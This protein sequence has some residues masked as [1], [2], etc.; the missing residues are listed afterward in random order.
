MHSVKCRSNEDGLTKSAL[1]DLLGR[2]SERGEQFY[3]YLHQNIG[4]GWRRRDPGINTK[5]AEEVF[6]RRKQINERVV[7]R[8]DIFD[9]LRNLD[10]Q[11]YGDGT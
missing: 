4:Q 1:L 10:V 3:Y 7:A 6:E 9:R 5:S 11:R 8:T 2:K